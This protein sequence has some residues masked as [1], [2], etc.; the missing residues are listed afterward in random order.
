M[1]KNTVPEWDTNADGNT[2]VGGVS[3]AEGCPPGNINNA[4]RTVMAQIASWDPVEIAAAY[5]FLSLRLTSTASL[6]LNSTNH[7]FQI[8]QSA[9]A[10]LRIDNNDIQAV[11]S[12]AAA[13]L[14]LNAN[15]GL[16]SIGA[17]GLRVNGAMLGA[18]AFLESIN[19]GNWS[20]DD[21]AIA[22][23]GTG[24]ST[25]SSARSNLGLG[26]YAILDRSDFYTQGSIGTYAMAKRVNSTVSYSFGDNVL[27]SNLRASNGAG[28]HEGT[29]LPGTWR[30]M[31]YVEPGGGDSGTATLFLRVS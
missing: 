14:N 2:D 27:G 29:A 3:I 28:T 18:L 10:N 30:C 19:N 20:G 11:N 8:G 25:A 21:L 17:G 12:A 9:G 7:P 24:A 23:G 4:I 31:G 16:V 26:Q 13:Q 22:N 5:T 6:T 15:G 1:A